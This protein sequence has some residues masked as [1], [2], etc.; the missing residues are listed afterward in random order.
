MKLQDVMTSQVTIVAPD[1]SLRDAAAL[2]ADL[3]V[4]ALPVHDGE[5]LRGIVTDRDLAVRAVANGLDPTRTPVRDVMTPKVVCC[6]EG[7]TLAHVGAL[8]RRKMIRRVVV[9]D[10]RGRLAGVVALGDLARRAGS[11]GLSA[12]ILRDVSEP[13]TEASTLDGRSDPGARARLPRA[14]GP[15]RERSIGH[16]HA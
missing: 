3:H 6:L 16:D 11:S 13:M 14:E 2:M 7:D 8:M 4:G 12:E 15:T 10:D 5:A 9:L 1:A